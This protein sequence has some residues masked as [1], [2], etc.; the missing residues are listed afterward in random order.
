M[1]LLNSCTYIDVLGKKATIVRFRTERVDVEK[2]LINLS[3]F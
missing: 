3:Y 1:L 2:E